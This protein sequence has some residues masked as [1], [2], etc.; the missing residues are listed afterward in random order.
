MELD[1]DCND[2]VPLVIGIGSFKDLLGDF[3]LRPVVLFAILLIYSYFGFVAAGKFF[4]SN[5]KL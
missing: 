5:T 1:A 2:V 3:L 4:R